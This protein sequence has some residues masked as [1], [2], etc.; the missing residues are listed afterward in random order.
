MTL[1]ERLDRIESLLVSLVEKESPRVVLGLGIRADR[2]TRR[3]HL[4]GMAPQW[5]HPCGEKEKRPR[6][7][8][9][10]DRPNRLAKKGE[11]R[12]L[13]QRSAFQ[14]GEPWMR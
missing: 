9:R 10:D 1:E 8:C 3:L 13:S 11:I 12:R 6:G 2:R 4:P 14:G 5:S 7:C